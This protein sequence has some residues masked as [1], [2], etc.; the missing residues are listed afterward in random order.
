MITIWYAYQ[1]EIQAFGPG[2]TTI[3][4]GCLGSMPDKTCTF[5]E[6]MRHVTTDGTGT[7]GLGQKKFFPLIETGKELSDKRCCNRFVWHKLMPKDYA[8]GDEVGFTEFWERL[9]NK[10]QACRKKAAELGK[11][12]ETA[13]NQAHRAMLA[14]IDMRTASSENAMVKYI[15][16]QL[17]KKGYKVVLFTDDGRDQYCVS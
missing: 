17:D 2:Q 4:A 7:T 9:T 1:L 5:D 8:N 12:V 3:G 11:D 10:I 14:V 15:Q 6:F 16:Q 13:L